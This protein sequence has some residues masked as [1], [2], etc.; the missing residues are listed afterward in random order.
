MTEGEMDEGEGLG[1]KFGFGSNTRDRDFWEK[2]I[3][4]SVPGHV[5]LN[6]FKIQ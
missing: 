4:M 3:V 6:K 2:R 5:V 1:D